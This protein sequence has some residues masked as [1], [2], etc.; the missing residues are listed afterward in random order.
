MQD[1]ALFAVHILGVDVVE[2]FDIGLHRRRRPGL[3]SQRYCRRRWSRPTAP[4][5]AKANDSAAVE[6]AFLSPVA[7]AVGADGRSRGFLCLVAE[8][9]II[10]AEHC[11]T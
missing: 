1:A 9:L 3:F 2:V 5:A 4:R 8:V 7:T 11:I 10:Y 6:V